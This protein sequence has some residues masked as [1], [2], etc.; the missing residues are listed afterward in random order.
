[1]TSPPTEL[2]R[3]ADPLAA[4]VDWSPL[5][6]GGSGSQ[7]RKLL[8]RGVHIVEF[9][10]TLLGFAFPSLFSAGGI[11][12]IYSAIRTPS[13]FMIGGLIFG[14]ITLFAGGA[15]LWFSIIRSVFDKATGV[16]HKTHRGINTQGNLEFTPQREPMDQIHAL[17]LIRKT[18]KIRMRSPF[19][20][21][22]LNL[23]MR[24]GNRIN[25]ADHGSLK[26]IRQDA[27]ILST[28]LNKPLWD[29][30]A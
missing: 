22:E 10:P 18:V 5:R 6:D 1:M 8:M 16:F 3:F 20:S 4:K 17:Q 27:N 7:N 19:T 21:Y 26:G 12:L 24:K 13:E 2:I 15:C 11:F 29:G 25:I 23:V 28:F 14:V 30:I 9:R